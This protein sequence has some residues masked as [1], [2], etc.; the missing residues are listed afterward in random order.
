[1]R[2]FF[3]LDGEGG[4]LGRGFYC[5]GGGEADWSGCSM[6]RLRRLGLGLGRGFDL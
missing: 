3:P 2:C 5:F 4:L 1:M 6:E